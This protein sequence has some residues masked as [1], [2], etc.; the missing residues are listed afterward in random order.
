MKL[1]SGPLGPE[2]FRYRQPDRGWPG[3]L[4]QEVA[5]VDEVSSRDTPGQLKRL[6]TAE[7]NIEHPR[8]SPGEQFIQPSF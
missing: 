3:N 1:H 5:E 2:V 4:D 6:Q 8:L 7:D